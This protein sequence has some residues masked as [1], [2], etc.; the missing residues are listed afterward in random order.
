MMCV[1]M[2]SKSPEQR[3]VESVRLVREAVEV[4]Q[5]EL[6]DGTKDK[7]LRGDEF[8]GEYPED[9]T[10]VTFEEA[11]IVAS[12]LTYQLEG[13]GQ[14]DILCQVLGP[15]N[16]KIIMFEGRL[17]GKSPVFIAEGL[18]ARVYRGTSPLEGMWVYVQNGWYRIEDV[19][20][21]WFSTD[22]DYVEYDELV[23]EG[24]EFIWDEV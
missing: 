12:Q 1:K 6:L 4:F 22:D 23:D 2:K 13:K 8:W 3:V 14:Y 20:G 7:V 5:I 10:Y 24:A 19:E 15:A 21:P 16:K 18:K 9:A 11:R 17:G